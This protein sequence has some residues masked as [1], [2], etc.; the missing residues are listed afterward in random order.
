[1]NAPR[2]LVGGIG[3]IFRGD[4]G[5]G[6]EV[7]QQLA[8]RAWPEGVQVRDFGIRGFDL[9]YAMLEDYD[10][11][12]LVDAL[13]RGAEPGTLFVLEA[14]L[15][16]DPQAGGMQAGI[17]THSLDP[18]RVLNMVRL[19]G[20]RPRR[21]LVVGCEPATFGP[22]AEGQMGLSEA[23]QAAIPQAVDLVAELIDRLAAEIAAAEA[24]PGRS[25]S[26]EFQEARPAGRSV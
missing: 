6:V 11:T 1:M 23:V 15:G 17:E 8:R 13:S 4:D 9:A 24:P 25:S 2:I 10:A 16:P 22:E 7:A 5:F 20:G 18:V 14:D 26:Q 19:Y 12:I 21:V 3:N